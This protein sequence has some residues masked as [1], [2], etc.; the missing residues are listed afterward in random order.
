MIE[1]VKSTNISITKYDRT[2]LKHDEKRFFTHRLVKKKN[3]DEDD[4]LYIVL[5][6]KQ[7]K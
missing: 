1:F 5:R 3:E 7:T 6:H 4:N 2:D